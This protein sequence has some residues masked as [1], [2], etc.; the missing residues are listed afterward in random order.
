MENYTFE[1][2]NSKGLLMKEEEVAK[3]NL[4]KE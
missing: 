4:M 3:V 2:F 1:G